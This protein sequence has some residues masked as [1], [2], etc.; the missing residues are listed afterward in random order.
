MNSDGVVTIGAGDWSN[1]DDV[2]A[3]FYTLGSTVTGVVID[4]KVNAGEDLS[5]LFFKSPN[6]ATITGF[7]NIDTSKVTD[8]SYM[9]C[10]TSVADFSSIS[11]WDVSDSENFDSMFTSN[12]KVQSIDLSHWEL[13]QAQ[14]IKMRRMFAADTALI[15]MDLSAWNMSMVTNINGMFAGNDLNTMALKSVDLHGWNLKNVTDMGT[16]F[17]FDNSLTSV[18]MSGWQTSSNLSSVDS[19]F[20]GTSSLA[21]LDLSS[22]DLQGVTRKYMLLSQNKLYDPIS[23]SLSTL[24]LGTMSVLTDT[25]L[26][27]IPTGTG[28]TGKWVNQADATQTYTSSE[29]M[30]LY[31]GVDSPADTITWVWETSPSYADFTSKNVTGLIAGPK[32]TWRVADSV[33]TLKDVNG[34]DIYA[35]ADTVVK[36]ISVNGDTAVTTVDT[37]TAGTYQ[38]DLQ[39]TDAYGKVW[40]RVKLAHKRLRWRIRMMLLAWSTRQPPR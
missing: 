1:V 22:I 16:M 4:G 38:V 28:Y 35:T 32:T 17:N 34:T 7:Q 37:Q 19:M 27:D 33:A 20:R 6:L 23:S 8:F 3:L 26:P 36:V 12:S 11:H 14:S 25:G 18:N 39:Y 5:Y 29:L 13:S 15:S 21:S 30:A 40:I 2:S 9:F 24:T 31:N 10:G